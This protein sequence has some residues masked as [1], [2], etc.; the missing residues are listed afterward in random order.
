MIK[1]KL[2][3]ISGLLALG[4]VMSCWGG[5]QVSHL[6][7]SIEDAVS[8]AI[9]GNLSLKESQISLDTAVRNKNF[10][11][12]SASPSV[13]GSF[14][15][16]NALESGTSRTSLT[17]A[18]SLTL[19]PSIYTSIKSAVLS[20]EQQEISYERAVRQLEMEVRK[21][22]YNILC[23][24]SKVELERSNLESSRKQY[25]A[26]LAKYNSGS[27]ARLDVLS[28]QVSYQN[29]QVSLQE[30]E[31][32]LE[33]DLVS[34][35][36]V[37]ALDLS[38]ELSFKDSL[39][40]ILEI[41]DIDIE[42]VEHKVYS[43][44]STKKQLEAAKNILLASRFSA[45][46]PSITAGYTYSADLS[47]SSFSD[48]GSISVSVSIPVDGFLPWSQ[49]ALSVASQKD[50][51]KSL[52]ISIQDAQVTHDVNVIKYLREIKQAKELIELRKANVEVAQQ[53]YEMTQTAYNRG[54]K[55][56]ISLQTASD[57]LNQSR[58]N[59]MGQSYTLISY[60]LQL[61]DE[62]GLPYGTLGK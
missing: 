35:K 31:N 34:F 47:S 7:L 53:T 14:S 43:I 37:L 44:E 3:I 55:D 24:M 16:S 57:N 36:Q 6:D 15:Y 59:L 8:I 5:E 61:E 20:Y 41:G 49:G 52:E 25:E 32:T 21:L 17:G 45:W 18:A 50:N 39:D 33:S 62:L 11:W 58:V 26:N 4:L 2:N 30:A 1:R 60:I 56:L 10:A 27:L 38:T 48:P 29:A 54:T 9:E 23:D 22:Y 51:I 19:S 40:S 28:A 46:G 13:R 12:S 42:G